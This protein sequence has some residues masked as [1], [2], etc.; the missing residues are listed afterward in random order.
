M[1]KEASMALEQGHLL[2]VW[3][4]S[5]MT[6]IE[7]LDEQHRGIVSIINSLHYL[8]FIQNDDTLLRSTVDMINGYAKTHFQTEIGL[9]KNSRYPK[10]QEHQSLH[11]HLV[12]ESDR[13]FMDC[14][15]EGGD[16]TLYLGFLKKWWQTHITREDMAHK[17]YLHEYLRSGH[18]VITK[19]GL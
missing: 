13:I 11:D 3:N 18:P 19:R 10:L 2:I 6:G 16:P 4:D 14:L 1:Q 8:L 7:I 15:K 12:A 9:L 17:E 5:Y